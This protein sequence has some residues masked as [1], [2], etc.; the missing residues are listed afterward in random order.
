M[1]QVKNSYLR[2]IYII[3]F[4][5]TVCQCL[6][7]IRLNDPVVDSRN[8]TRF[9]SKLLEYNVP[10]EYHLFGHGEHGKAL[11]NQLTHM[12]DAD[13]DLHLNMWVNMADYWM[14]RMGG[15]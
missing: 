13:I 10:V 1:F 9:I 4:Q 15:K 2:L 3:I 7:A 5:K 12:D 8:S 6:F 14:K 11:E